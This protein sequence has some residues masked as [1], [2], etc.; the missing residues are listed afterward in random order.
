MTQERF[1]RY[2]QMMASSQSGSMQSYTPEQQQQ[3]ALTPEMLNGTPQQQQL[4]LEQQQQLTAQRQAMM[5]RQ[6]S[7]PALTGRPPLNGSDQRSKSSQNLIGN[8]QQQRPQEG[9]TMNGGMAN[10]SQMAMNQS[11]FVSPTYANQTPNGQQ[12][13][14]QLTAAQMQ[15]LQQ[16]Q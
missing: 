13:Q 10:S 3:M 8:V 2:N 4:T 12:R 14:L 9:G 1:E 15:Q 7:S 6:Y 11:G 5:Q 16:Q